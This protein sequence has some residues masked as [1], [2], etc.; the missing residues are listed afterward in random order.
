ME[1][2]HHSFFQEQKTDGITLIIACDGNFNIG[3][4]GT[5]LFRIPGDLNN[6]KNITMGK[7][8]YCGRKTFDDMGPLKGRHITVLTSRDD[9]KGADRIVNTFEDFKG[10]LLNDD[11]GYLVGGASLVKKLYDNIDR[12]LMTKVKETFVADTGIGNPEDHGFEIKSMSEEYI[13]VGLHY[14]YIEYVRK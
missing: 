4:N 13:E 1:H 8:L 11:N 14:K 3:L 2:R 5:M 10:L 12:I 9:V 7:N 6:Y